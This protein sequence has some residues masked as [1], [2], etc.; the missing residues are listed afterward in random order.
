MANHT[1]VRAAFQRLITRHDT[2]ARLAGARP[3]E[4][5]KSHITKQMLSYSPQRMR[6]LACGHFDF[7]GGT[8]IDRELVPFVQDLTVALPPAGPQ[9]E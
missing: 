2:V 5:G 3:A 6:G 8:N 7:K 1:G 9:T 4:S